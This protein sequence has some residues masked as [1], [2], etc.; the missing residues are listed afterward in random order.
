M[1]SERCESYSKVVWVRVIKGEAVMITLV[2]VGS[3]RYSDTNVKSLEQTLS[4]DTQDT[5]LARIE[6]DWICER[7]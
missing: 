3:R 7:G 2:K 5:V 4:R 1:M 6:R